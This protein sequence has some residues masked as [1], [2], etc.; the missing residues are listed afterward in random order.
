M[1]AE[2][3][4]RCSKCRKGVCFPVPAPKVA[5]AQ[6]FECDRCHARFTVPRKEGQ[7]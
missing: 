7:Q 2:D 1:R 4:A 6:W 5:D 3:N